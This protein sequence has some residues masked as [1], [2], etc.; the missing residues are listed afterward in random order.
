MDSE[1]KKR[2]KKSLDKKKKKTIAAYEAKS[3]VQQAPRRLRGY[4]AIEINF[5]L[6]WF[7]VNG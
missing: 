6:V 7:K 4:T 3:L 2:K 5:S 1:Q